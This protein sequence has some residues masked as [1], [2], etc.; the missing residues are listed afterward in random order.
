M[1]N[2]ECICMKDQNRRFALLA[3]QAPAPGGLSPIQAPALSPALSQVYPAS[4]LAPAVS[5]T[6]PCPLPHSHWV[7]SSTDW[8]NFH[9]EV[10][11]IDLATEL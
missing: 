4:A 6:P 1:Q 3:G 2:H 11:A 9:Q 10:R 7:R 5:N 8:S